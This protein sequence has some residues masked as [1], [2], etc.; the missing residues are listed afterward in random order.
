MKL[1]DADD[2]E[3]CYDEC[4]CECNKYCFEQC[5][6]T[7]LDKVCD[8]SCGCKRK[9]NEPK[10]VSESEGQ[11]ESGEVI[12]AH[13]KDGKVHDYDDQK[14]EEHESKHDSKHDDDDEKEHESE[15]HDDDDKEEEHENEQKEAS[16]EESHKDSHHEEATDDAETPAEP[17]EEKPHE[18]SAAAETAKDVVEDTDDIASEGAEKA[19]EGADSTKSALKD[20][21]TKVNDAAKAS[22]DKVKDILSQDVEQEQHNVPTLMQAASIEDGTDFELLP[23]TGFDVIDKEDWESKDNDFMKLMQVTDEDESEDTSC[24]PD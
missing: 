9:E 16:H 20:A 2:R 24:D 17:Q 1:D 13:G 3:A 23:E 18:D 4:P 15:A 6:G 11:V 21:F 8:Q 19:E 22:A 12:E 14:D 5:R 10:H 7:G